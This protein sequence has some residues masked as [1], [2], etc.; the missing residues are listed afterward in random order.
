MTPKHV[1][2]VGGTRGS[3]LALVRMLSQ[4]G[5]TVSVFGRRALPELEH[6]L[7]GIHYQRLDLQDTQQLSTALDRILETN[8]KLSSLVF[9]QRYRGTG[10]S[11]TGELETSLSVTER[12]I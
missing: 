8:G 10:D 9:F 6:E 3:G 11:W 12:M 2:V 4:Q 5:Q 1:L 7:P